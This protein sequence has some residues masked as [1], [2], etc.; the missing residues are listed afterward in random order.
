MKN[1]IKTLLLVIATIS[2]SAFSE[3]IADKNR[4]LMSGLDVKELPG[5]SYIIINED[6]QDNIKKILKDTYHLPIIKYWKAGNKVG[7]VLEAIGKHEFI[8]TGYIV[9]NNKI[10]D[11]KV[12]V[13]RENYGYEIEHDYFLDQIRGNSV[14]KNGKLVKSIANISGA[15]LSVKAMRKLSKLSLYLY[16][17]I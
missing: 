13:Y 17:I 9:E 12:L 5:H 14:K 16:T 10:I 11:A 2:T 3:E 4:F 1:I 8:T 6:I 7:F 15:T